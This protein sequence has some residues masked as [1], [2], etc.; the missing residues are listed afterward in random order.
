M[1][2]HT[3]ST[4]VEPYSICILGIPL[5]FNSSF[6]FGPSEAPDLIREGYFSDS[7]NLWT[8]DGVDLANLDNLFDF[9]N[10]EIKNSETD[11]EGITRAVEFHL[12]AGHRLICLGGDHSI[13]YPIIKGYSKIHDRFNILHFD[14]H[15]DLYDSL[16]GNPLSHACPFARIMEEKPSTRLVQVGIR[17]MNGH[18]RRQADRFG[19]EVFEMCKGLDRLRDI[20]FTGPVYLSIDMDCLDPAFAPGVS[21]HEP[22]GLSTRQLLDII[23][24]IDG[25][26]IGADIVEYNPKRDINKMTSMVAAKIL[27]EVISKILKG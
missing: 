4:H 11:F 14:A 5:D 20:K 3:D 8:E 21:H 26:V 13:T 17:T 2:K 22:G 6:L 23:Q 1:K 9:G 24:N 12:Q 16:D 18:Q 10:L 7:S 25:D 19:V 27:K 15:P